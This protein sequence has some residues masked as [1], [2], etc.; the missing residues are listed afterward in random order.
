[1]NKQYL[2]L[3]LSLSSPGFAVI[4]LAEDEQGSPQ[5]IVLEASH[6][7]TNA[8]KSRGERLQQIVAELGRMVEQYGPFETV[9]R[10][11]GFSRFPPV[12]Q[13]LF[14]VV[15]ASELALSN[16]EYNDVKELPPTTV[17]KLV[18]GDGKAIKTEVE[19]CVRKLLRID[20]TDYFK[21]DDE[22]DACAV[23]LAYLI[24]TKVINP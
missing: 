19:R 18:T 21:T 24:K 7:K 3:D 10:E 15:G 22:S 11:K 1:M 2:G 5:P 16:L 13:A 8:K 6:V 4:A 12:T 20:R 23:V 17:K 14:S 9:I